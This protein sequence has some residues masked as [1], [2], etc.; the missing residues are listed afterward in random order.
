M[1][2]DEK[3]RYS[4]S[5]NCREE[6]CLVQVGEVNDGGFYFCSQSLLLDVKQNQQAGSMCYCVG[7][8]S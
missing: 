3:V 6:K 7:S 2:S 8:G 1:L 4:D 5:M